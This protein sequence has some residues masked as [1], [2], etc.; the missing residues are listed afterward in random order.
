[1]GRRKK[2]EPAPPAQEKRIPGAPPPNLYN[3]L[4]ESDIAEAKKL[5]LLHA[6]MPVSM[7]ASRPEYGIAYEKKGGSKLMGCGAD[8]FPTQKALQERCKQFAMQ[9]GF[10]LFVS[11]SSTRANGGGN[12]KYRCKKLHGQ[13]F[14]DPN[15]PAAKLQCPFYINGY[16]KGTDWKITR[17]CFLHNHYKF[18]GWRPAAAA[19]AAAQPTPGMP[20]PLP[21]P[22]ANDVPG[23]LPAMVQPALPPGA[24]PAGLMAAGANPLLRNGI[25]ALP[26]APLGP[27]GKPADNASDPAATNPDG[28]PAP[29]LRTQRNTT[30]SMKALC[31]M[32]MDE[33]NKFPSPAM[34]M[35]KLDG[36][37]IKRILL[38][39]G[40]TINHMMASRIKRHLQ[41]S[42]LTK[43]RESFQKLGGYLKLVAEKNP[44]SVFRMETTE[45]SKFKR[46]LFISSATAS[47]VKY[48]RKVVALDHI[49]ASWQD[50]DSPI[51]K[52]E[53]D[54]NDDAICGVY[55]KAATKD[56]NDQVLT[57]ALALVVQ[58]DQANWEWFLRAIESTH[59]DIP[60]NEYTV[61][62]GRARGL[63]PAVHK[64][65]PRAS[66]HFC[67]RRIVEEEM[68]LAKKIP[69]T[70]DKKQ[71]I[72][73]LA[74]SDSEAEFNALRSEL[75]R[76]SE[77]AVQ[78]LDSLNR[79]NWVKYAFLEAFRCP[80]FNE[81]TSDLSMATG[82]E[83]FF[84]QGA[85]VSHTG[86]F[87]EEP[88]H[89][90]QPLLAFNQYFMKIAEN[91]HH[92]RQSVKMRPP[93]ELVPMRD[94]QLQQIL[95]G[96]QRCEVSFAIVLVVAVLI[97]KV[98]NSLRMC[99]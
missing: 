16:G 55:L 35:V 56:Y 72:F 47:A 44:G 85:S 93:M 62:A 6:E 71:A 14:F 26:P 86:W 76:T 39:Q 68:M 17:A 45:D 43:I 53:E 21:P 22:G 91:F 15:T 46:A 96:S 12:V 75:L 70:Q 80:T 88:V 73:N 40:H 37:M 7:D 8:V 84:S 42:R 97:N 98:L 9:R 89:S 18:I 94:A 28:T 20:F 67:M 24:L 31:Q 2:G 81:V 11:G 82:A 95:Q 33:V 50:V 52:L 65:W 27:T 25:P 63:Q 99:V 77:A 64:L 78:Y 79:A 10:Q 60:F 4:D 66:L 19:A 32:V 87:G 59:S 69:L 49:T 54:E 48:C 74:R 34:V 83:E 41:E 92:R 1:M 23:A 29:R 3:R 58:E 13:Q 5:G 57:F 90:S 30:M 61:V 36:K 38:S 51:G